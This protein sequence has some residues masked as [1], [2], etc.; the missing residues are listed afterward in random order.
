MGKN[1]KGFWGSGLTFYTGVFVCAYLA[2]W[3]YN[4]L[5]G[6]HFDLDKLTDLYKWLVG[7]HLVDSGLNSPIPAI[8]Q[9]KGENN[10]EGDK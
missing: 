1:L 6:P 8:A 2:A 4:A 10:A 3:T 9:F 7:S 5:N